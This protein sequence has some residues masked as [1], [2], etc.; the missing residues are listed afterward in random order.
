MK[1]I[2]NEVI[3]LQA[4][5]VHAVTAY[6]RQHIPLL[7][8]LD[9]SGVS[10]CYILPHVLE[11]DYLMN[12][13]FNIVLSSIED[14]LFGFFQGTVCL[15]NRQKVVWGFFLYVQHQGHWN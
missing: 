6:T 9:E 15:V 8:I 5:I 7:R 12:Y 13:A 1:G 3:I 2:E 14:V 10:S 4:G 11:P